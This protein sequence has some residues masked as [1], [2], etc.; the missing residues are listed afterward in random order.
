MVGY[1]ISQMLGAATGSA[2]LLFWGKQGRS[3]S[4]GNTVPGGGGI[5]AAFYGEMFTTAALITVLFLFAGTRSLRHLTPYTIPFLYCILVCIESPLS[6]CSTNP[7]RSFGPA[8]ISGVYTS[9]W[10]YWLAPLAGV[11]L[12]VGLFK[13]LRLYRYYQLETARISY[14]NSPTHESIRTSDTHN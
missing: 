11:L 4:Y 6:G 9:Y 10:V 5:M 3:I 2:F 12:V 8:F 7:A 14:H 13:V 1:I